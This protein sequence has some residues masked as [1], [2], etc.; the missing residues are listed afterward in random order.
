MMSPSALI[1]ATV[2][3]ATGNI[4]MFSCFMVVPFKSRVEREKFNLITSGA[5]ARVLP[6]DCSGVVQQLNVLACYSSR[7]PLVALCC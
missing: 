1:G 5:A 4:G 7:L 6:V 2:I 3:S